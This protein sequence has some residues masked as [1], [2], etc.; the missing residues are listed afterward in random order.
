[1]IILDCEQGSEEWIAARLGIPTA[2]EFSRIV[3]PGGKPSSS[4]RKYIAELC[5]EWALGEPASEFMGTEWTERGK[6]LEDEAR[7]FFAFERDCDYRQVGLVYADGHGDVAASPDGLVPGRGPLEL[8]CPMPKTHLLWLADD[9]LPREHVMQ[10]QGQLWVCG[11]DVGDFMSYCPGLPP[12]IL[13]VRADPRIQDALSEHVP[14]FI[15]ELTARKQRLIELGVEPWQPAPPAP[16]KRAERRSTLL[17]ELDEELAEI[18]ART[19]S[20]PI[21]ALRDYEEMASD[22]AAP[23]A[24]L[25][26][27]A[28]LDEYDKAQ[29]ATNA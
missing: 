19:H 21:D 24:T 9:G 23:G 14:A 3:T 16:P 28:W 29:E 15:S 13:E 22:D 11:A 1:M 7:R 25:D 20:A 27:D 6:T 8:K 26:V 2:S 12:L 5:A 10:T 17:A 18:E 4:Q